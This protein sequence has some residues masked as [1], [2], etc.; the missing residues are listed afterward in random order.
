MSNTIGKKTTPSSEKKTSSG[1]S[2]KASPVKKKAPSSAAKAPSNVQK[3]RSQPA[4][5]KDQTRFSQ[6][7]AAQS[8]QAKVPN[9]QSWAG[10]QAASK[11]NELKPLSGDTMGR[12]DKG[13]NVSQLQ[14]HL[15]G[16][17][18]KLKWTES[19]GRRRR[20]LSENFS[21]STI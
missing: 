5:N 10:P 7:V 8:N 20:R 2:G 12:R 6:D 11:S 19:S 13:D 17:G 18:A 4:G 15:N 1:G 9:F 21:V 14:S 16:S 3:T